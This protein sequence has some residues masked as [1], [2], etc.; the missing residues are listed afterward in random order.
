MVRIL[1]LAL[2]AA[3]LS[4]CSI[5][6]P[7]SLFA[8]LNTDEEPA[9]PAAQPEPQKTQQAGIGSSVAGVWDSMKSGLGFG[10][11][12]ASKASAP[13]DQDLAQFTPAQALQL[14][15][16][17]R[18]QKGLRP[19]RLNAKLSEAAYKH[20]TDL[21]KGDRISHYGSDGSDTWDRVRRTG[22]V[23]KVT[24]ENVGTGQH[25]IAEVFKGWQD[26]RDHN[27][28][29]LLP[30]AEE[31]GIAMVYSPNTQFKTFWTLVLS[32]PVPN[33][34]VSSIRQ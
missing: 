25:S 28:N 10:G 31:I 29:L 7:S 1:A 33:N 34:Q 19:V 2:L 26:S 8:S 15:N 14:V 24:A 4:A 17:Y 30:D 3:S 32:A 12:S 21:S 6:P 11:G 27:A 18:A 22:Y 16:D 13:A 20:S 5:S 9:K 23:A